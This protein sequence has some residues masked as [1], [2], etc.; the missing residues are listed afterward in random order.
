MN[1][2]PN[3]ARG[4]S[5]E[6]ARITLE[7]ER[8]KAALKIAELMNVPWSSFDKS[9]IDPYLIRLN[10]RAKKLQRDLEEIKK[11][12]DKLK[13]KF[14]DCWNENCPHKEKVKKTSALPGWPGTEGVACSFVPSGRNYGDIGDLVIKNTTDKPVTVVI[15]P[16]LLLKSS[17]PRVQD[18]Y[19]AYVFTVILCEG[20]EYI[21]KPI[22]IGPGET[23]V[24]K[25]LPGFCPDFEK[26][27]ATKGPVAFTPLN[28]RTRSPRCSSIPLNPSNG[29]M[30]VI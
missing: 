12:F 7:I 4:K 14:K 13:D 11:Y 1:E 8:L 6:L 2:L 10:E 29:L 27:P 26:K 30:S 25:H 5:L 15:P 28:S 24:V 3:I 19:L 23:Y 16:G 21:D 22:T 20:A 9:G 17:D 18:L